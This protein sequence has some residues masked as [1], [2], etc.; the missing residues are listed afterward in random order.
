MRRQH[1]ACHFHP[2]AELPSTHRPVQPL[3]PTTSGTTKDISAVAHMPAPPAAPTPTT[4]P[5]HVASKLR[6][7]PPPCLTTSGATK[8]IFTFLYMLSTYARERTAATGRWCGAGRGGQGGIAVKALPG[9]EGSPR[10]VTPK[11]PPAWCPN[12]SGPPAR[13]PPQTAPQHVLLL[14]RTHRRPTH[15][16]THP[17]VRPFA[18]SPMS[19]MW[20]LSRRPSSRWMV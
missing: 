14:L 10:G 9:V 13:A 2:H 7:L 16:P 5:C 12:S 17:P 15:P 19:P 8:D 11:A 6:L 18:R 1:P 20:M 3:P 4:N